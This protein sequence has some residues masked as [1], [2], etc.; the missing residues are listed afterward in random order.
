MDEKEVIIKKYQTIVNKYIFIYA[1][2][3][4]QK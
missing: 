4:V 1:M 2:T 3:S